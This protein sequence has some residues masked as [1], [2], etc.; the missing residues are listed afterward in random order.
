MRLRPVPWPGAYWLADRLLC[1]PTPFAVDCPDVTAERVEMLLDL[2]VGVAVSLVSREELG[3]FPEVSRMFDNA[4]FDGEKARLRASHLF[5]FRDGAT[6]ASDKASIILDV[7][8]GAI[9]G[10]ESVYTHCWAGRGRTGVIAGCWL[11]R[12]AAAHGENALQQLATIRLAYGM[13]TPSP[14]TRSQR[15]LV[16]EWQ[17]GQ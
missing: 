9:S 4:V 17:P 3:R 6:P 13:I 15:A 7:I 14:E 12:H 5:L 8:D 2:G 1:G 10:G 11:A 16:R